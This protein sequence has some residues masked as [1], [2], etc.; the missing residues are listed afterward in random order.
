MAS[1]LTNT[2]LID[3][4]ARAGVDRYFFASSACVYPQDRQDTTRPVA[5]RESDAYPADPEDGYGWEKLFSERMCRHHA[6]DYGIGVRIARFH[7]VYGPHTWR[8]LLDDPAREPL[9]D[10]LVPDMY[11]WL[12]AEF[13]RLEVESPA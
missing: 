2:H 11:D 7:N 12:P 13:N 3:A 4:A 8:S 9:R 1:V 10:Y 6:E 5:L